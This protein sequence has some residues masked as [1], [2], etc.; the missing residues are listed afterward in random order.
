MKIFKGEGSSNFAKKVSLIDFLEKIQKKPVAVRIRILWT[1]V[2]ICMFFIVVGWVN[3]LKVSLDL[4]PKEDEFSQKKENKSS[5]FIQKANKEAA[6]LKDSLKASI[7]ALWK[8]REIEIKE[9]SSADEKK[10]LSEELFL[11]NQKK[12]KLQPAE[13]PLVK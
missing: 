11:E 4:S 12:R 1:V 9:T 7:E 8:G 10:V 5:S 2:F 3:S 13:L 6:S